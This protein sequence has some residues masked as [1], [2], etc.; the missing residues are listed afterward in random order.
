MTAYYNDLYYKIPVWYRPSIIYSF[1][2]ILKF[3]V[4]NMYLMINFNNEV[5]LINRIVI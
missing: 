2:N 4:L 3:I 1:D 5:A